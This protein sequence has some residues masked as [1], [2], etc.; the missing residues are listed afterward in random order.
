MNVREKRR[1]YSVVSGSSE[2]IRKNITEYI[3]QSR[4]IPGKERYTNKT[5]KIHHLFH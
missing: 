4:V 5:K 3:V 1:C 2:F